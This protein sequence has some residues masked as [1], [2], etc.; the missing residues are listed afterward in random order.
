MKTKNLEKENP[1]QKFL[2]YVEKLPFNSRLKDIIADVNFI[3][4]N[5]S[6]YLNYP[7]LFLLTNDDADFHIEK[8]CLAGYLFYQSTL[9]LDAVIDNNDNHRLAVAMICQEEAIKLLTSI[10][11]LNSRYW[12]LWNVRRDEYLKAIHI[13]KT[14]L[15]RANEV[16]IEE[17]GNLADFKSAFGKAAIDA[18]YVLDDKI[19]NNIYRCL[20]NSH[21]YFS[22]AFQINDDVLDFKEDFKNG[23]FNWAVYITAPHPKEDIDIDKQ[24]KLFYSKRTLPLLKVYKRKRVVVKESDWLTYYSSSKE[25][26]EQVK[27]LGKENFKREV[28]I[29]CKSKREMTYHETR[30]QFERDVLHK[31]EYLNGNILGRFFPLVAES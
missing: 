19:D 31:A 5:P 27:A 25:L 6:F 14:Y 9:F 8:L 17:Y 3:Q 2:E 26:K 13:E 7:K 21:K 23:Q 30:L 1:E 29:L 12:H 20:L 22:I 24:K 11:G 28:L 15:K 18:L 10:F 16:T 4:A